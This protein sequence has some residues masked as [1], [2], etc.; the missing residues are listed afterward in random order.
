MRKKGIH[1]PKGWA[2]YLDRDLREQGDK[3]L[4]RKNRRYLM[5][6]DKKI[7]QAK[8]KLWTQGNEDHLRG[9]KLTEDEIA[10]AVG[11]ELE[12]SVEHYAESLR[13][14][15]KLKD[16]DGLA[17]ADATTLFLVD[18][19]K[20]VAPLLTREQEV[21]LA[22]RARTGD[23]RAIE[24]LVSAN[25]RLCARLARFFRSRGLNRLLDYTDLLNA[26]VI[27]LLAAVKKFDPDRGV[28]LASF[29]YPYITG[30]IRD[31][32]EKAAL[33]RLPREVALLA[34][35][36]IGAI[37]QLS[38]TLDQKPTDEEIATHLGLPTAQVSQMLQTIFQVSKPGR[39][40]SA[41]L[42]QLNEAGG[43]GQPR[44]DVDA[45]DE[46]DMRG[47]SHSYQADADG[48]AF[49][50]SEDDGTSAHE[51][52][53]ANAILYKALETLTKQEGEI[54]SRYFDLVE[55]PE[56]EEGESLTAIARRLGISRQRASKVQQRA[57]TKLRKALQA[58]RASGDLGASLD[59]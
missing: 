17:D 5:G 39:S 49:G 59:A 45:A 34:S 52:D 23:E 26:G 55:N 33:I 9:A 21:D 44:F 3:A 16:D 37:D 56:V 38:A 19:Q 18:L 15:N 7:Q 54:M 1:P 42:L 43:P 20:H 28:P 46:S 48:S 10:E 58:A 32:L 41:P 36:I 31:E 6:L 47:R 25:V 30:A 57:L 11:R 53:E 24:H 2:H 40:H 29:A 12:M 13:A 35:K 14:I 51:R 27:G 22:R 4:K 50:P 8:G